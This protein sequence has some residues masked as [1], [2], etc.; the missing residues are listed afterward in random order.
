MYLPAYWYALELFL[1]HPTTRVAAS[2][3][4][5]TQCDLIPDRNLTYGLPNDHPALSVDPTP[6]AARVLIVIVDLPSTC[7]LGS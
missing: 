6:L 1:K 7:F 4:T 2:L 5:R 3:P